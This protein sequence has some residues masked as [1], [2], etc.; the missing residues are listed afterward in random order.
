MAR[1]KYKATQHN[2]S[3]VTTEPERVIAC[4]D[5]GS[6]LVHDFRERNVEALMDILDEEGK[7][8]WELIQCS[9]HAGELLC[10]WKKEEQEA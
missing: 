8:G 1:W 10:L 2:L 4:D 9:Y 3:D 5:K 7:H 6:C